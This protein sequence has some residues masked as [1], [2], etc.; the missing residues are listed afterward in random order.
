[1]TDALQIIGNSGLIAVLRGFDPETSIKTAEALVAGG[2]R[3]LEVTVDSP[4]ALEAIEALSAHLGEDGLVGAGT[5]L[6]AETAVLAMRAGAR[7]LFAPNLNEA[8]IDAALRYGRIAIPGV[9][10]PTEMVRAAQAG[11]PVVKL[12]PASIV[13]PDFIKQVRGPLPHIPIIPTGGIDEHNAVDYIRAGAI[14]VG[15]GGGLLGRDVQ[16][17]RFDRITERA[18]QLVATIREEKEKLAGERG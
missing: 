16:E 8:V 12:F 13:G 5:V 1:M 18:R 9:M 4:G 2:V 10:T 3:V 17:G 14:A 11:A 15:A 6:D 7:F